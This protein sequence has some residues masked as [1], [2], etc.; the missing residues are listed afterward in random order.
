[1]P[2]PNDISME[3]QNGPETEHNGRLL[4]N[5]LSIQGSLGSAILSEYALLSQKRI[6]KVE[7]LYTV[8]QSKLNPGSLNLLN[9]ITGTAITLDKSYR[10]VRLM[11]DITPEKELP[12]LGGQSALY[13][14]NVWLKNEANENVAAEGKMTLIFRLPDAIGQT[15]T[16][17][18]QETDGRWTKILTTVNLTGEITVVTDSLGFFAFTLEQTAL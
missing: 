15:I 6:D 4:E 7:Q 11:A 2:E 13:A 14:V 16:I 10:N 5:I 18:H 1:M 12:I 3:S 8:L 17:W 9:F